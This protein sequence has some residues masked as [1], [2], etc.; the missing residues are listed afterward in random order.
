MPAG[1]VFASCDDA[2]ADVFDGATI[3]IG[4]FGSYGGLPIN[5]IPA[6][7]RQGAKELTIISNHGGRGFELTKIAKPGGYLQGRPRSTERQKSI[8]RKS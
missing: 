1:K 4:G 6:L 2:V 3:M 7:A 5:L 8:W